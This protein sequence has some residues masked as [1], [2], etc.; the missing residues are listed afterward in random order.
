LA[1]R[2][3]EICIGGAGNRPGDPFKGSATFRCAMISIVHGSKPTR[4]ATPSQQIALGRGPNSIFPDD[5]NP[6]TMLRP[7]VGDAERHRSLKLN[8]SIN[9]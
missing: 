8:Y 9:L 7:G 6:P 2:Q 1:I 5:R 4:I 3:T